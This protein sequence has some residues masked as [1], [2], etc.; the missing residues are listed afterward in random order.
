MLQDA[1]LSKQVDSKTFHLRRKKPGE[2]WS[3]DGGIQM[4]FWKMPV[5]AARS[6]KEE[7]WENLSATPGRK[8]RKSLCLAVRCFP[9]PVRCL[10]AM[11]D[12]H[13]HSF[14]EASAEMCPKTVLHSI[15]T[16][17]IEKQPA[18]P[19]QS[20]GLLSFG[21]F[22]TLA[23]SGISVFRSHC[24]DTSGSRKVQALCWRQLRGSGLLP[25]PAGRCQ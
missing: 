9:L 4:T 20:Q 14:W 22:Q 19:S 24:G 11:P 7:S 8:E 15:R 23:S 21:P 10:S 13:P 2:T 16:S 3:P 25:C 1:G 12:L 17:L 6:D 18:C 5:H